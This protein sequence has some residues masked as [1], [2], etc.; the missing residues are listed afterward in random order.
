M[1]K[2]KEEIKECEEII[3]FLREQIK[4]T[5]RIIKQQ[6]NN[7]HVFIYEYK[8]THDKEKELKKKLEGE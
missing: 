6:E 1:N 4:R 2:T 8:K 5:H 3:S 7:L